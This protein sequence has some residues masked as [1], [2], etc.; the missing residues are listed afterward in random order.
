MDS[1]T[2]DT[3][4]PL[5]TPPAA[6]L[7]SLSRL[8]LPSLME[9]GLVF[10]IG[11]V[12]TW[13]AGR[14][15]SNASAAV[16]LA[17]YVDWL[18]SLLFLSIGVGTSA[19]VARRWGGREQTEANRAASQAVPLGI[20]IGCIS[21]IIIFT[22]A[23][24]FA[25]VQGLRAMSAETYEIGVTYLRI[26]ALSHVFNSLVLAGNA[27]L[28]GSGD[29]RTPMLNLAIMNVTN[30]VVSSALVFGWGVPSVGTKGIVLGTFSA[31]VVGAIVMT[32]RMSRWKTGIHWE[33]EWLWPRREW[34]I[35]MLRIGLPALADGMLTWV[36]HFLFIMVIA[37]LATGELGRAYYAAHMVGMNIEAL[38]YL[39]AVAWGVAAA[40]LIGQSLGAG[41]P[42]EGWRIGHRAVAQSGLFAVGSTLFYYFGADLIYQVMHTD[43]LV[44]KIGPPALRFIAIYQ[45]PLVALIIYTQSLR[46]AG[47]TRYPM[48]FTILGT[49]ILRVPTAYFFG[50]VLN[51]GLIGAWTGM[52]VDVSFRCVLTSIRFYRGGWMRIKV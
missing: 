10:F 38:T 36:G 14:I 49:I 5:T 29:M 31:R 47:D 30:A 16:G 15:G 39:P 22:F 18:A 41:H 7:P 52:M 45:L 37:H 3:N 19:I 27:A 44:R 50:I 23:P 9:Q 28:R 2:P 25:E 20:L 26:S 46:G 34:A 4:L 24:L 17:A 1:N 12:D 43:P 48:L 32:L 42:Q 40:S 13:L 6:N 8:A 33:T 35:R 21:G 11:L 51:G